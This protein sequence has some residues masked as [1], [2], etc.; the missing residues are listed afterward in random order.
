MEQYSEILTTAPWRGELVIKCW[1]CWSTLIAICVCYYPCLS[2]TY[3]VIFCNKNML[4]QTA[5]CIMEKNRETKH[6]RLNMILKPPYYL[7]AVVK[8]WGNQVCVYGLAMKHNDKGRSVYM[9]FFSHTGVRNLRKESYT[10][11]LYTRYCWCVGSV[12][13][14]GLRVYLPWLTVITGLYKHQGPGM[15]RY[16]ATQQ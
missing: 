5:P 10:P 9:S 6:Y 1:P 7:S 2:F 15:F 16:P 13:C 3:V 8:C 4:K 11:S 12:G 14:L